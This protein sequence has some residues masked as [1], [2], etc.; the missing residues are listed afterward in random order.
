[1]DFIAI[2]KAFAVGGG[3]CVIAQLLIDLTRLTPARILV[4]YVVSG[5]ALGALGLYEPLHEFAGAG[6]SVPL[7]GFGG[8]VAR[9]VREAVNET[10]LIGA[11]TGPL[12]AAAGGTTAAICFGYL[13]AIIFT[14]KPKTMSKGKKPV[15]K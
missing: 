12:S 2:L 13:T 1:M 5:V 15:K 9:G 10:G 8:C 14:G 7:V 3:F 4:I 11:L 6:A